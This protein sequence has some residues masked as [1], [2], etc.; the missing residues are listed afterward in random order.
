VHAPFPQIQ[1]SAVLPE[2]QGRPRAKEHLSEREYTMLLT[3]TAFMPITSKMGSTL[4]TGGT[5]LGLIVIYV[6]F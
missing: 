2:S 6:L 5:T 3:T 1:S 4:L